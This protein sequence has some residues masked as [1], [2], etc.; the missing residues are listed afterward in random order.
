M[1]DAF[2]RL[3]RIRTML[4]KLR[5]ERQQKKNDQ[6]E[7]E[8]LFETVRNV[9]K[10]FQESYD[11][12][13]RRS[14]DLQKILQMNNMKMTIYEEMMSEIKGS[15][16]RQA[17]SA[18]EEG[19]NA[20]RQKLKEVWTAVDTMSDKI[21]NLESEEKTCLAGIAAAAEGGDDT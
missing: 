10:R 16:F 12:C 13:R 5:Q 15:S 18:L 9:H 1:V 8:E 2:T 3:Q 14:L 21:K 4:R 11:I 20:V 7:L 19:K 6:Q 17:D